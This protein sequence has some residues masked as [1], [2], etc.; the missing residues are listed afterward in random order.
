MIARSTP[1]GTI[2][3]GA[4]FDRLSPIEQAAVVA[5]E[6]GHIAHRHAR[7]RARWVLTLRALRDWEGFKAMCLEQEFEADRYAVARGHRVGLAVL[8]QSR[9]MGGDLHPR[10]AQRL[11]ALYV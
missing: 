3:F 8:L 1:W 9:E 11:K 2:Q 10:S 4:D 6:R 7:A 5:H